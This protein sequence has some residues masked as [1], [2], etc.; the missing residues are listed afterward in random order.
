[1]GRRSFKSIRFKYF[2]PITLHPL[3]KLSIELSSKNDSGAADLLLGAKG[4]SSL[5]ATS[6][7]SAP[8]AEVEGW[9]FD[10]GPSASVGCDV[11]GALLKNRS[12]ELYNYYY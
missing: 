11:A 12:D 7:D 1:M 4:S 10:C 6:A 3:T 2:T 8:A 5:L 9:L